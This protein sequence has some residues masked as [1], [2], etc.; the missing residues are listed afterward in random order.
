VRFRSRA[1]EAGK[2]IRKAEGSERQ[3]ALHIGAEMDLYQ[4]T[5]R[6][7]EIGVRVSARNGLSPAASFDGKA[8]SVSARLPREDT[9]S[10]IRVAAGAQSRRVPR[11]FTIADIADSLDVST[12]T[13]RRWIKSGALPA[14]HMGGIIRISEADFLAFLAVRRGG[15]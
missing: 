15:G 6:T 10:G 13:V 4:T 3:P 2:P 7:R 5:P 8:A 1:S 9:N 12:R 14:H 11:F